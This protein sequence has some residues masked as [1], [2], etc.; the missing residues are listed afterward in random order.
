MFDACLVT[1]SS[2]AIVGTS[3]EDSDN[4]IGSV[5]FDSTC[6]NGAG[7]YASILLGNPE[8]G[9]QLAIS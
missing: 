5:G 3:L 8:V 1:P 9:A 4:E 2:V 7:S 6:F